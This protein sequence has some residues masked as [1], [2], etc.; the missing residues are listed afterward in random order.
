M[1]SCKRRL[2]RSGSRNFVFI[3]SKEHARTHF[4]HARTL[5]TVRLEAFEWNT[6]IFENTEISNFGNTEKVVLKFQKYFRSIRFIFLREIF[7]NFV[8]WKA[9]FVSNGTGLFSVVT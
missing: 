8:E 2:L 3:S 9:P 7:E 6:R 4:E 5:R 1:A